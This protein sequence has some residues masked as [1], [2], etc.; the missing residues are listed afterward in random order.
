MPSIPDNVNYLRVFEEDF[1]IKRF[2]EAI[3]DFSSIHI[4]QYEYVEEKK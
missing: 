3:D 2:I 1:K 4:D